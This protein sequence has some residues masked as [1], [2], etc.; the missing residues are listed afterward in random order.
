MSAVFVSGRDCRIGADAA[1]PIGKENLR[2]STLILHTPTTQELRFG[3]DEYPPTVVRAH[4]SKLNFDCLGTRCRYCG[5][6][7]PP[8]VDREGRIICSDRT[9]QR[10]VGCISINLET[11]Y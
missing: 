10:D 5:S 2:V 7:S 6:R 3:S 11:H 4:F 1:A 9:C 8:F